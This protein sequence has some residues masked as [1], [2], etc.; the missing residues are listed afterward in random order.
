MQGV[1][2]ALSKWFNEDVK[3]QKRDIEHKT[4]IV[5]GYEPHEPNSNNN[6]TWGGPPINPQFTSKD[7]I[8]RKSKL[9]P[10]CPAEVPCYGSTATSKQCP[11][12]PI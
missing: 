3:I 4:P 1:A 12:P 5:C 10:V 9:V 11:A 6:Y 2:E 7:E 8:I